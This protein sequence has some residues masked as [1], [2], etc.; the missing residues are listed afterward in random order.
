LW[1]QKDKRIFYL[2]LISVLIHIGFDALNGWG[3]GLFEPF[4]A[5][6]VSLGVI[7]IV[8]F[9]IWSF[10]FMG[11]VLSFF[12]K[13]LPRHRLWKGVW[14]IILFYTAIQ[15]GMAFKVYQ[16]A[17]TNYRKVALVADFVPGHYKVVGKNGNRVEIRTSTIWKKGKTEQS[18]HS[19]ENA[20]LN[21]LF[22][23]NPRAAVLKQWS[24]FVVVVK[25][26]GRLGIFDP[27]FYRNGSSFLSEFE[28]LTGKSR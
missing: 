12:L 10:I 13:S 20:D 24:P 17:N 9:A 7:P 19:H 25:E 21:P 28:D 2:A 8:D 27:R 18:F 26:K 14:S 1:K 3:T 23:G 22:R 5:V 4:S 15:G 6:R 11:F 16:Q